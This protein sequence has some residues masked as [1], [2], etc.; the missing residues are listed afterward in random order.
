MYYL[1]AALAAIVFAMILSFLFNFGEISFLLIFLG[2]TVP[3]I[4]DPSSK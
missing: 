2:M 3:Y 4:E 1:F